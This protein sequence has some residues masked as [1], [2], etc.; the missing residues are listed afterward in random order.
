[1]L[2]ETTI[3]STTAHVGKK[4]AKKNVNILRTKTTKCIV[5]LTSLDSH[6]ISSKLLVVSVY[7]I[8][9]YIIRTDLE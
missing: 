2:A 6:L 8:I 5:A 3:N 7:A 9:K 1:M 4:T